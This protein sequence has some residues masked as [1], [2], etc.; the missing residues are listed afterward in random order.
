MGKVVHEQ[1]GEIVYP[2]PRGGYMRRSNWSSLWN[3]VR[4]GAG[5]PGQEFY[6]LKHRA[7]Q[8]MV[9]P[10]ED[11]G[12]GLDPATAAEMVGHDDGGYLIATVYTKLGQRRAI[13]R[14]ASDG[15][16]S[17]APGR[18]RRAAAPSRGRQRRRLV[19]WLASSRTYVVC[20]T[21][22][23]VRA[24]QGGSTPARTTASRPSQQSRRSSPTR[25]HP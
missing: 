16:L 24:K 20:R 21:R 22:S 11:G 4:T 7:I 5:M 10:I 13:A 8:W 15:R 2:S 12:L 14:A 9:D 17:A 23:L 18:R 6:E 3:A 25:S 1:Y 19:V